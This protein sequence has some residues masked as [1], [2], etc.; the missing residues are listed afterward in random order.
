MSHGSIALNRQTGSEPS[1]VLVCCENPIMAVGMQAL[2]ERQDGV[3]ARVES[4]IG[5][6]LSVAQRELPS[7]IIVISPTLTIDNKE[8]L[9]QFAALS[10]VV[11]L[12]KSENTHRSMEA[13]A[14]GVRAVLSIESSA[15]H[16]VQVLRTVIEV[17]A[18]VIP[19][20]AHSSLARCARAHRSP[21]LAARTSENLTLRE[22]EVTLLL[23]QGHTNN[24]IARKL[25][26]TPAT[27]RSHVHH[28]LKKLGAASRA[29]AI[30][31][32]YETGLV[33]TIEGSLARTM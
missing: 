20:A 16:L 6:A 32:A 23:I 24:E 28:L 14:L 25:S 15:D 3:S 12:A 22:K 2:L 31:L 18:I 1:V 33:D 17:D 10:K 9:A 21:L 19:Q 27:V 7:A 30:A 4:N 5:H 13:L 26:I 29:Q 8:E 11:F